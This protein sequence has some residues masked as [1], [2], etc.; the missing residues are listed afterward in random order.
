[1][2]L[3]NYSY[4]L[5]FQVMNILLPAVTIPFLARTLGPSA[6]G[7]YAYLNALYLYAAFL[8]GFALNVYGN[9]EIAKVREDSQKLWK[10]VSD[11]FS[12]Q[13]YSSVLAMAL[14]SAW[15]YHTQS[16]NVFLATAFVVQ[17]LA[18]MLDFSWYFM[19]IEDMRKI[20][21][22]NT[23]IKS[24]AIVLVFVLVRSPEDLTLY[25]WIVA[26]A[27][28]AGN[29]YTAWL[30]WGKIRPKLLGIQD[31][32]RASKGVYGI[33]IPQ[34]IMAAYSGADRLIIGSYSSDE[35]LAAYDQSMK[36]IIILIAF[37]TSL[38]PIM[39]S[40]FSSVDHSQSAGD[41]STRAVSL[42]SIVGL[43]SNFLCFGVIGA[44]EN[45]V[46]WFF[47]G[48]FEDV[49]VLLPILAGILLVC[50]YG[51]VLINQLMVA[52]GRE[53]QILYV[54]IFMFVTTLSAYVLVIP[55]WG[56]IGAAATLVLTNGIS[57]GVEWFFL[58]DILPIRPIFAIT[59]RDLTAGAV[60]GC[61]LFLLGRA[62][63]PT[64]F[65]TFIQIA[66]GACLYFW[67]QFMFGNETLSKVV[68][69][70]SGRNSFVQRLLCLSGR[71][72]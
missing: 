57:L 70:L 25:A 68:N 55:R 72:K 36:I 13:V 4:S 19:G 15:L 10:A 71:R 12:I 30:V 66:F 63:S 18:C 1:M 20:M 44:S 39:I 35:S 9:R 46:P 3:R 47:G 41:L 62:L 22:R 17:V 38:R 29:S 59:I 2:L 67:M 43:I 32:F 52:L 61:A 54:L 42:I 33:F 23:I 16:A 8:A 60:M 28:F 64:A 45:F 65:S 53:R 56:A 24:V 40:R 7:R 51:D 58:K 37:V 5:V 26:G 50:S 11:L 49:E 31:A 6:L 14:L 69:E 48:R 27:T 21:I 34:F